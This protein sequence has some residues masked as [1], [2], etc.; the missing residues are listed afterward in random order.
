MPKKNVIIIEKEN[1]QRSLSIKNELFYLSKVKINSSAFN[2]LQQNNQN[3]GMD[4]FIK[5]TGKTIRKK[6]L[7]SWWCK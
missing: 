6:T 5:G 7:F 4:K 1:A 2:G 3:K